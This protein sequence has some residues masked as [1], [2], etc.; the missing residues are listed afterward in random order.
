MPM[1]EN[2]QDKVDYYEFLIDFVSHEVRNPLSAVIMFARLMKEGSYGNLSER[3]EEVLDRILANS[4]RIEHMTDDFLNLSRIESQEAYIRKE[5]CDL[6][7]DIIHPAI[8]SLE[9][10]L[11]FSHEQRKAFTAEVPESTAVSVDRNLILIVFDNLFFNAVKYGRPGGRITYGWKDGDGEMLINV[12]NEGQG[13]KKEDLEIIFDKFIRLKDPNI[14]PEKG[15][16]LGLYNVRKIISM[17]AGRIW[18]ESE[19]G[20]SFTVI[21]TLPKEG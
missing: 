14:K 7:A 13:V 11:L 17:H 16:G 5:K 1:A 3:Q 9:K 19:Y 21:F 6:Y 4:A 15:T 20:R 2:L 12:S 18:A 10:K 8:V